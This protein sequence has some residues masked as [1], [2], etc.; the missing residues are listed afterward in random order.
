MGEDGAKDIIYYYVRVGLMVTCNAIPISS[1]ILPI[2]FISA[3]S[4]RPQS[5]TVLTDANLSTISF[6]VLPWHVQALIVTS[7]LGREVG[8]IR[9]DDGSKF[10]DEGMKEAEI[11][12]DE[13]KRSAQRIVAALKIACFV[14][15]Y[16]MV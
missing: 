16:D 2:I 4:P 14:I 7:D 10:S 15:C 3:Q 11:R 13:R 9:Y 1:N 5:A 12:V 8:S 6:C